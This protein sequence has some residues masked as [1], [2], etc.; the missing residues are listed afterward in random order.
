MFVSFVYLRKVTFS[1][2]VHTDLMLLL[3]LAPIFP[4]QPGAISSVSSRTLIDCPSSSLCLC[5]QDV[6][7]SGTISDAG[8]E[9]K[10]GRWSTCPALKSSSISPAIKVAFHVNPSLN[11]HSK[12]C[13]NSFHLI[14]SLVKIH[15]IMQKSHYLL[16]HCDS[17]AN[18]I[19]L[20]CII[21]STNTG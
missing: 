21:R 14:N 9:L 16:V 10:S 18:F 7:Q 13:L 19:Y 5:L 4:P 8:W 17:T 15:K 6:K 3:H 11:K 2:S 20:Y 1:S 12:E